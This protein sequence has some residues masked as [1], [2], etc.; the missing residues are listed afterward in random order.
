[1]YEIDYFNM[2]VSKLL[3]PTGLEPVSPSYCMANT[4]NNVYQIYHVNGSR[5]HSSVGRVQ[6][7]WVQAPLAA[8]IMIHYKKVCETL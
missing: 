5:S 8:I 4:G 6:D 3:L 1:M 7:V 2:S